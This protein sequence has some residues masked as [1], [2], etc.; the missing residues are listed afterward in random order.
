MVRL[1]RTIPALPEIGIYRARR[2]AGRWGRR[3]QFDRPA[4][5]GS[6][7]SYFG[8]M[9]QGGICSDC[10]TA[11]AT[12]SR[13]IDNAAAAPA[14]SSA[15][16]RIATR[17]V[18]LTATSRRRRSG[19]GPAGGR[20]TQWSAASIVDA[21]ATSSRRRRASAEQV[22]RCGASRPRS[23]EYAPAHLRRTRRSKRLAP[24]RHDAPRSHRSHRLAA[25]PGVSG[26]RLLRS[27]VRSSDRP[28]MSLSSG[29]PTSTI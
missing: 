21:D 18:R 22:S 5:G 15:S 4:A 20:G 2:A 8:A 11:R 9:A 25:I 13:W 23:P 29:C 27:R 24:S 16:I 12:S 19:P 10:T 26:F 7:T 17:S 6:G 28:R 3:R 14:A 1:I